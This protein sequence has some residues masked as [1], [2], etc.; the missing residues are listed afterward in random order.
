MDGV[1]VRLHEGISGDQVGGDG[2]TDSTGHYIFDGDGGLPPGR[3]KVAFVLPD[4]YIFTVPAKDITPITHEVDGSLH[5]DHVTSD[6]NRDT[7]V[8]NV[9]TTDSKFVRSGGGKN[10]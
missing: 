10:T 4:G 2:V 8:G 5:Y 1:V 6:V 7:V 3:Y 9:G